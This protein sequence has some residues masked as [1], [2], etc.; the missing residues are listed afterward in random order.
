MDNEKFKKFYLSN[1][2]FTYKIVNPVSANKKGYIW[3]RPDCVV[4]ALTAATGSDWLT[5]FDY[6]TKK[7]R[8]E[9]T[10]PND[11][12][13]NRRWFIESGA[14]WVACKAVKG[15]KRPTAKDFALS[16]PTGSYILSLANHDTACVDGKIIDSFNC[17][18]SAL[19]GYYDM[20]N[21]S[22]EK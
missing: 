8:A 2:Y 12:R 22:F 21:F 17:G 3:D 20:S 18:A 5:A 16:H 19:V 15:K 10:M 7:A 6:L 11:A 13:A 9:Y 14:E 1:D 4:R